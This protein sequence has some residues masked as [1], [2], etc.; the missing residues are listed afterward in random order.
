MKKKFSPEDLRS[1]IN[2]I[3]KGIELSEN[4]F[5]NNNFEKYDVKI[6]DFSFLRMNDFYNEKYSDVSGEFKKWLILLHQELTYHFP[7][8]YMYRTK[9]N[10]SEIKYFNAKVHWLQLDGSKKELA[11]YVGKADDFGNDTENEKAHAIALKK[12]KALLSEKREVRKK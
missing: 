2:S 10:N 8:I 11:V 9:K 7:K 4:L 3:L 6:M 12:I 1:E 5:K